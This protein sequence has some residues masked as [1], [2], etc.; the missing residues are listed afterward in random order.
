MFLVRF[1]EIIIAI[2]HRNILEVPAI[3]LIIKG[4]CQVLV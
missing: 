3:K 4:F 2:N 1:N